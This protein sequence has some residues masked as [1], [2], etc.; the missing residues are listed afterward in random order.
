L[1]YCPILENE[2]KQLLSQITTMA[3]AVWQL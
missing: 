2:R 1:L 3:S